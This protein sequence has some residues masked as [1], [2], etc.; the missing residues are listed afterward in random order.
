MKANS[1]PLLMTPG[2]CPVFPEVYEACAQEMVHHRTPEFVETYLRATE[3][4][5]KVFETKGH[6]FL[7]SSSGTGAMEAAVANTVSPGDKVLSVS[8]GV[9][10]ARFQ[11]I[12]KA[13]GA[14]T[15]T[16][17]IPWGKG[18]SPE[19]VKAAVEKF[20]PDITTVTFNETS[21]GVTNPVRE[22]AEIVRDE[23]VLLVDG[24]SAIGGIK[25]EHDKW[26]IGIGITGS[27]KSLGVPPGL[28]MVAVSDFLWERIEACKSPRFYFDLLQY[29]DKLDKRPPPFTPAT[30]LVLGLD[31]ALK[32]LL[33]IGLENV[34]LRQEKI[35]GA[36]Q[37]GVSALGLEFFAEE[38]YRSRMLTSLNSPVDAEPVRKTMEKKYNIMVAGGQKHLKG[39]IIRI[40]HMGN[41]TDENIFDTLDSL[42]KS[43]E[44]H[45]YSSQGDPV[46]AAREALK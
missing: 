16:L 20:K 15:E 18:A 28:S 14:K 4:M 17:E 23:T 35:A 12:A 37:A 1:A 26:G 45:G 11:K 10:G 39:K 13:F 27:Q 36:I 24:I 21:T 2:P 7:V 42:K 6:V 25:Y 32:K 19:E 8:C 43:L 41:I 5:K 44:E 34:Y 22:L 46:K 31:A 30:T 40:G 29:R 3:N 38:K 33:E 9:F